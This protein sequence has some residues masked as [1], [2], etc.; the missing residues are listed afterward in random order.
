MM[1]PWSRPTLAPPKPKA[2]ATLKSARSGEFNRPTQA[3]A[4]VRAKAAT[5]KAARTAD[6]EN[7]QPAKSDTIRSRGGTLHNASRSITEAFRKSV[8]ASRTAPKKTAADVF[9]AG[10]PAPKKVV[11]DAKPV[12]KEKSSKAVLRETKSQAVLREKNV[13]NQ[14]GN[15]LKEKASAPVLKEKRSPTIISAKPA[16]KKEPEQDKENVK[17]RNHHRTL[18]INLSFSRSFG[19]KKVK[20][21]EDAEPSV[22]RR[23]SVY[24]ARP[25]ATANTATTVSGARPGAMSPTRSGA[26]SPTPSVHFSSVTAPPKEVTKVYTGSPRVAATAAAKG[27]TRS[28]SY[29]RDVRSVFG[30]TEAPTSVNDS[31]A[32]G[33]ADPTTP[34]TAANATSVRSRKLFFTQVC[35]VEHGLKR[36]YAPPLPVPSTPE[37]ESPSKRVSKSNLREAGTPRLETIGQ[38]PSTITTTATITFAV[39]TDTSLA[40]TVPSNTTPTKKRVSKITAKEN[41]RTTVVARAS[42]SKTRGTAVKARASPS[43]ATASPLKARKPNVPVFAIG[44]KANSTTRPKV[45]VQSRGAKVLGDATNF[46]G[47]LRDKK[48]SQGAK[49]SKTKIED[50]HDEGDGEL[51]HVCA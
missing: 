32:P 7:A 35:K 42:P 43:K 16:P 40:S 3:P 39:E 23:E 17:V 51:L 29:A 38:S 34:H 25:A 50:I 4:S 10:E 20:D 22:E 33:T 2:G 37:E 1:P 47:S 12:L 13:M 14:N 48:S 21:K 24:F 36:I 6:K 11:V 49:K 8:G 44:P 46:T 31:K 41:R 27:H 18:S 19:R 9:A 26:I 45:A 5:V 28:T 15:A 30:M